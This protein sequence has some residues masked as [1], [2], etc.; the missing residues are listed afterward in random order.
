MMV[1][2]A[3]TPHSPLL[4]PTIGRDHQDTFAPTLK[5]FNFLSKQLAASKPDTIILM[6]AQH[7]RFSEAFSLNLSDPY[8]IDLTEF[9][10]LETTAAFRPDIQRIDTLQRCLRRQQ[11]PLSINSDPTLDHAAA[12]PLLLLGVDQRAT[13]II[14]LSTCDLDKKQHVEFGRQ[15]RECVETSGKRVAVIA[16]GDLSHALS[17]KAPAGLR[18]EGVVFDDTIQEAVRGTSL[19][20]LLSLEEHTVEQAA[21]CGYKPLLSLFGVLEQL[22]PTTSILSYQAPFGVGLLTAQFALNI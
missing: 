22:N 17:E 14:P 16:S 11:V 13:R 18:K 8:R 9:G 3:Y 19:S 4:L 6:S 7:N 21:E 5:A 15:L 20:K 10:D 2:C 1:F 12:V